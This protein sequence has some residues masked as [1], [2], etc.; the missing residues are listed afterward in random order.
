MAP[1]FF[2]FVPLYFPIGRLTLVSA[3]QQPPRLACLLANIAEVGRSIG[4]SV[5]RSELLTCLGQ[6]GALRHQPV[7]VKAKQRRSWLGKLQ[8]LRS[9]QPTRRSLRPMPERVVLPHLQETAITSC[10]AHA[11]RW[12]GFLFYLH[13]LSLV[14]LVGLHNYSSKRVG[15][16][17]L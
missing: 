12:V 16:G 5:G 8:R 10:R 6:E 4:R 13:N 11:L 3:R 9:P 1:R 7:S 14:S 2:F 17:G 15:S